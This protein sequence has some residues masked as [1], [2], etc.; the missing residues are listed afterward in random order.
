MMRSDASQFINTTV[1]RMK[2]FL[3]LCLVLHVSS[4]SKVCGTGATRILKKS[5][6]VELVESRMKKIHKMI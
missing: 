4:F 2:F 6:L 5:F 3:A 1:V